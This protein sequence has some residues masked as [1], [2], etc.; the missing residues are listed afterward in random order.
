MRLSNLP[1]LPD[2]GVG[3]DG[4]TAEFPVCPWS[5]SASRDLGPVASVPVRSDNARVG[6]SVPVSSGALRSAITPDDGTRDHCC[7]GPTGARM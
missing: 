4:A 5:S 1:E 3:H 2:S 6:D 7:L